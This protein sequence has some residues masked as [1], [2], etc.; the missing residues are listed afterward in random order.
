MVE[1]A[2]GLGKISKLRC[3]VGDEAVRQAGPRRGRRPA[4]KTSAPV[5]PEQRGERL[6]VDRAAGI[7]ARK[8][9]T[10]PGKAD[11]QSGL[12]GA[13]SEKSLPQIPLVPVTILRGS[14]FPEPADGCHF[15]HE[16]SGD[17][18][19]NHD[20]QYADAVEDYEQMPGRCVPEFFLLD[21][22]GQ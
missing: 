12:I 3:K 5:E 20:W 4:M 14:G 18:D 17:P 16:P 21:D 19:R 9:T 7:A 13:D 22:G 10:G 2:G 11:L 15:G 6:K 8:W 1:G